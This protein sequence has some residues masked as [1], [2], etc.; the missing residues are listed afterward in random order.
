MSKGDD[1]IQEGKSKP[2]GLTEDSGW[3]VGARRT[4]DASLD[5]AWKFVFSERGLAIWLGELE[6]GL[7][8]EANCYRLSDGVEGVVRVYKP[9]SH[10]RLTWK[11][12]AW[13]QASTLQLRLLAKDKRCT[14]AFHQEN[15]PSQQA[16]NKRCAF[17]KRALDELE[18]ELS[19]RRS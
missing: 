9:R 3:Q 11:P 8:Q 4:I 7:P 5:T 14:I 1:R 12:P 15:M 17:F 16:R 10:A 6:G 13:A 19:S 2:V 18:S